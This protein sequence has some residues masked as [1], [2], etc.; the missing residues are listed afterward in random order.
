M[1]KVII[2]NTSGDHKIIEFKTM[3]QAQKYQEY[4]IY[5]CGIDAEIL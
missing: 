1:Y 5:T 4:L 3:D 2:Y